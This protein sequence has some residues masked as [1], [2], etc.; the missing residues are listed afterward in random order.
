MPDLDISHAETE[1]RG[2]GVAGL[3]RL[4]GC[5][6]P[7]Q[8]FHLPRIEVRMLA[9]HRLQ[10]PRRQA[11]FR[12]LEIRGNAAGIVGVAGHQLVRIIV[13][14]EASNRESPG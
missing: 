14:L 2:L 9:A 12:G 13:E 10:G 5:P 4:P 6:V 3:F 7:P 1:K 11:S 8:P